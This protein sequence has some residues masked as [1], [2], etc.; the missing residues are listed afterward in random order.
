MAGLLAAA[1]EGERFRRIMKLSSHPSPSSSS[2]M[3]ASQLSTKCSTLHTL[4]TSDAI[5]PQR[6]NTSGN[7]RKQ[8]NGGERSE[9]ISKGAL[10][11]PYFK[12]PTTL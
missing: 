2:L 4:L 1:T 10:L 8:F 11:E 12:R 9:L 6:R 7:L 5:F 3:Q